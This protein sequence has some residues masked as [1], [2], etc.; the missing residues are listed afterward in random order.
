MEIL[1]SAGRY[2]GS[3]ANGQMIDR[4]V[5]RT[6]FVAWFLMLLVSLAALPVDG[7]L[8]LSTNNGGISIIGYTGT[9]GAVVIPSA[10]NGYPVTSIGYAAFFHCPSITSVVIPDSV[11]TLQDYAFAWCAS[12][13]NFTLGTNV[14][15][16]GYETFFGCASLVNIVIPGSVTNIGDRAFENCQSLAGCYFQGNAPTLGGTNVFT[17]DDVAVAYYLPGF[18]GWGTTFGGIPAIQLGPHSGSSLGL[19]AKV[20]QDG[21]TLTWVSSYGAV[22]EAAANLNDPVWQPLYTNSVST[23]TSSYTDSQWTNYPRRFYRLRSP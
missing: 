2:P 21:F 4:P 19:S 11:T 17:S 20:T 12:V 3:V 16:I 5:G 1:T 6:T 18:S 23:G 8:E 15:T 7:Q 9:G 22:V 13:T 10:T 14:A